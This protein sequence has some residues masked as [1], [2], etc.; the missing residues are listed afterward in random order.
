MKPWSAACERNRDPI[1]ERL[2]MHFPRPTTVLEIGAGTGQHAVHFAAAVP[3]WTWIVTDVE[4]NLPGIRLWTDEAGLAN[5]RGPM[6]LDVCDPDWPIE[7]TEQMYSANTAHI[8]SWSAVTAMFAGVGRV[9]GSE[10]RFALY[11]PFNRGGTFTS[12]SNRRF[13]DALRASDPQMGIRDDR[14]L[15]RLAEAVGLVRVADDEMPANNRLLVW[16]RR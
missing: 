11:G 14:A 9:L 12:E 5:L 16:E 8:M 3:D 15:D 10:G 7:A 13:D 2:R 4:S 1:L 6:A